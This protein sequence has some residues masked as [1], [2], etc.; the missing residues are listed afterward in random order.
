MLSMYRVETVE[1]KGGKIKMMK[2]GEIIDREGYQKI[3]VYPF[4]R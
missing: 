1:K 3:R 2:N 4:E